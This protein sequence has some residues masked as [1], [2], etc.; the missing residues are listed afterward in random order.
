M[1]MRGKRERVRGGVEKGGGE[2]EWGL[3]IGEAE[4]NPAIVSVEVLYVG[5]QEHGNI[6]M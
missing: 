1:E 5:L 6:G 2:R 4:K 3:L